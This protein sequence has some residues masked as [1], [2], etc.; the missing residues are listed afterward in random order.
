VR[1]VL[2]AVDGTPFGE[3]ALPLAAA[4]AARAGATLRVAHVFSARELAG[5]SVRLL[6]DAR[7][8]LDRR[9][10]QRDY[11][12]G[13]VRRL[14]RANPLPMTAALVNGADVAEAV[15][16]ASAAADLVVMA[17]RG[18]GAWARFWRG[19]V[20]AAVARKA[21]CPVLLVRG[22]GDPPDLAAAR[23]PRNILVPLGG[24]GRGEGVV[25]SAVALGS[26]AGATYDLLHV[27]RAWDFS[28]PVADGYG[29][30]TPL[31][32][33]TPAA[34][35]H[36]Y[37]RGV[38]SRLAGRGVVAT[39]SVVADDRPVAEAIAGYAGRTGAEMIALTTR[40]RGPLSR[41]FRG[42]VAEEVAGRVGVPVLLTRAG[43]G[44]DAPA[45]RE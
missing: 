12:A 19:S 11:L 26:P 1:T 28:S 5:E 29:G 38:V 24:T 22:R 2:V 42:S 43:V 9:R 35:A 10:Q 34:D 27:T 17:T 31:P 14:A 20:T 40:G 7:W 32:G 25:R 6:A 16:E 4:I 37:L 3:H 41:L 21:R 44:A 39:G 45:R 8:V 15:C 36:A 33:E 18:R 30:L 23:L 13:L